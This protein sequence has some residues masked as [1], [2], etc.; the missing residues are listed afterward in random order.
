VPTYSSA[1]APVPAK[2]ASPQSDFSGIKL[3]LDVS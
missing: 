3:D 2:A 1:P